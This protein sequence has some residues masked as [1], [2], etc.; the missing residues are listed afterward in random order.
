MPIY[1]YACQACGHQIEA[2]QKMSDEPLTDCPQCGKPE[3]KKLISA[4][5]FQLKGTGWYVTDFKNK[6]A[7][8]DSGAKQGNGEGGKKETKAP[9]AG[10]S[11]KAGGG[12]KGTSAASAD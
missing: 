6:K 2:L 7:A 9:K 11:A 10:D 5:G 3:L 8:A 12:E 4:A 1:E